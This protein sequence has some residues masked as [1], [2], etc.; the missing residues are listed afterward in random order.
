MTLQCAGNRRA[1]LI[2]VRD[3]PGEDPWGPG[4]TSTAEWT[5]VSL[6]EVL[7]SAGPLPGAAHIAFAAPDVSQVAD[8]PQPYGGSIGLGKAM[9]GEVL[10]AWEMNG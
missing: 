6:A 9:A 2:Q 4:A 5:G 1:G 10:L 8:P 7:E 3:I